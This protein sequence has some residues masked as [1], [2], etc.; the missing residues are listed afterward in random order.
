MAVTL[1]IDALTATTQK[2]YLKTVVDQVHDRIPLIYRLRKRNNVTSD[3]G[4]QIQVPLR[5][6]KN[7]QT[8]NYVKGQILTSGR[9]TKLTAAVFDWRHTQVPI[10]YDV[11]DEIKNSGKQQIVNVIAE[12]VKSAQEDM[13]DTL[14]E[15]FF[16]IYEGSASTP[17]DAD[18]LGLPAAFY[19]GSYAY[20]TASYGGITR[21]A[22]GDWWDGNMDDLTTVG[23]ATTVSFSQWDF[24]VETCMKYKARRQD[25]MAV[26]GS[27]LYRKWKALVRSKSNND[28]DV[29]GMMA[30]AGFESFNIDG[31]ELVLDDNC[32]ASTFYMLDTAQ[33][34]WHISPKRN[35][36][37]TPFKSQAEYNNGID[38]YLARVFLSHTGL[39]C[40]KPRT[41]Y[42]AT[43]MA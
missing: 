41:S 40:E 34:K 14:S 38:E 21:A 15:N 6:G 1:N 8:Q 27:A 5:Y 37:M 3:G 28:C 31:V 26:C 4:S 12:E 32:P 36:K 2:L 10:K 24:M 35:F 13:M 43:A 23:A 29:S 33:W 39:V 42:M 25:L 11:D 7:T 19:G 22:I 9:D 16:G 20:G 30:K 18:P 17:G